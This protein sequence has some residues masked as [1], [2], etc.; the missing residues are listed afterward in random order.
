MAKKRE[1]TKTR[2]NVTPQGIEIAGKIKFSLKM[3][4]GDT[5]QEHVVNFDC[6]FTEEEFLKTFIGQLVVD[7]QN[8]IFRPLGSH[9]KVREVTANTLTKSDI[10][11][12][13]RGKAP[14]TLE[15]MVARMRK[16]GY[17]KA[18]ILELFEDE[19]EE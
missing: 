8:R 6:S 13:E 14:E 1:F 19:S 2:F 12:G 11:K 5:P 7:M 3:F 18:Q 9:A 10:Y 17:T 16:K 4:D 15:Q